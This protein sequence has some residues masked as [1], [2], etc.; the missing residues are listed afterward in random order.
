MKVTI[1][2]VTNIPDGQFY[3]RGSYEAGN[4][5]RT[6]SIEGGASASLRVVRYYQKYVH[7]SVSSVRGKNT[8]HPV[9]THIHAVTRPEFALVHEPR[10]HYDLVSQFPEASNVTSALVLISLADTD[11]VANSF[12]TLGLANSHL[13][14]AGSD[15]LLSV[16]ERLITEG[17]LGSISGSGMRHYSSLVLVHADQAFNPTFADL[18][19][20]FVP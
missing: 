19:T 2:S 14:Q 17:A 7:V 12:L 5:E 1:A 11:F 13:D 18:G 8:E 16:R 4:V 6:C 20:K 3:Q 9:T 15:W 10:D